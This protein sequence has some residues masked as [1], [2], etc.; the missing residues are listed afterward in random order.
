MAALGTMTLEGIDSINVILICNSDYRPILPREF[1]GQIREGFD[2]DASEYNFINKL[3]LFSYSRNVNKY[4]KKLLN[5]EMYVAYIDLMSS[6]NK[7][8]VFNK[9]CQ[10]FHIIEEG[11]VNY[12]EY[13]DFNLLTADLRDFAWCWTNLNSVK[14][15]I[16]G[17]FRLYRGRSIKMERLPI[18]PNI[19]ASFPGV[20]AYCFSEL[21]FPLIPKRNK[22]IL[23]LAGLPILQQSIYS[24]PDGT[25]FWIGD[26]L[27]KS[28]GIRMEDF[29]V[30]GT[31]LISTLGDTINGATIYLKFRGPESS[32][33]KAA[34]VSF[35]K[36][37]GFV[38]NILD[39]EVILELIFAQGSNYKVC[40]IGSS[41]LIYA[42]ILGH[43]TFSALPFLSNNYGISIYEAYPTLYNEVYANK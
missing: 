27:A 37:H 20:K 43:K 7:Y 17:V 31:K 26:T 9:H 3:K 19:Y 11:I 5:G 40:G 21:A 16:Q 22:K 30:A 12:G 10:S 15:F 6:F 18:H 1:R 41:L 32:E 29:V 8:L 2:R 24:F 42:Y 28:Y 36:S 34:T 23:D 25:W 14:E 38:V 35:L 33:E 39:K 13:Y 4:I